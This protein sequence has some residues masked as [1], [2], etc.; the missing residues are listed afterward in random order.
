M[1]ERG[2]GGEKEE[3][4]EREGEEKMEREEVGGE[5]KAC[6]II[7]L[8]FSYFIFLICVKIPKSNTSRTTSYK[9]APIFREGQSKDLLQEEGERGR[10]Q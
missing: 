6:I 7:I 8:Y 3:E 4:R 10:G 2:G 5:I 9:A 1:G